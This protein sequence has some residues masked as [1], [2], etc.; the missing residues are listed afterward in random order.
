MLS[1]VTV[2]LSG[3]LLT[4][5][6]SAPTGT[7]TDPG[8]RK[9]S[10]LIVP[11]AGGGDAVGDAAAVVV[12]LLVSDPPHA[13]V[14]SASRQIATQTVSG[15]RCRTSRCI[16]SPNRLQLTVNLPLEVSPLG[17]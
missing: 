10:M 1:E 3:S 9:W 8:N 17:G 11:R 7:V 13:A 5:V 12:C 16:L 2:C 14:A 15:N 4:T 6:T